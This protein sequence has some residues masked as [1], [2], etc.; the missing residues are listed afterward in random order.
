MS[1]K[2]CALT[3]CFPKLS[4][5]IR[6]S[7]YPAGRPQAQRQRLAAQLSLEPAWVHGRQRLGSQC[8]GGHT[9][10]AKAPGARLEGE[11]CKGCGQEGSLSGHHS[12]RL[13]RLQ[14]PPC[15]R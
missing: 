8:T 12:P 14:H 10:G 4:K 9:V 7:W 3:L 5:C 2:S 1:P 13:L 11:Q 6:T 15:S